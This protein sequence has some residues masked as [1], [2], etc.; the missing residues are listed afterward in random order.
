MTKINPNILLLIAGAVIAFLLW[1]KGCGES[2]EYVQSSDTVTVTETIIVKGDS[3]PYEVKVDVPVIRWKDSV[4]E[5]PVDVDTAKILKAYF[6]K[7]FYS[8]TISD[9][10]SMTVII[11]DTITRNQVTSRKVYFQN[12]R[13]KSITTN[14]TT[15]T[16]VK[17]F[18][19]DKVFIGGEI[20]GFMGS[21][22]VSL[23]VGAMFQNKKDNLVGVSVDP[24]NKG[25]M[26]KYYGKIHF[27]W[28][29]R[30]KKT[31]N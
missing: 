21:E 31:V 28:L 25:V 20:G 24:F 7:N 14:T 11:N 1:Q 18:S 2:G 27:R 6:S 19:W 15:V 29:K 13:E 3:I 4:V 10:S 9:D 5:V 16:T 30:S 17:K 22:T 12:L 8:D 26:V 23:Q